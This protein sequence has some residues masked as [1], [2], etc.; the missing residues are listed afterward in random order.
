MDEENEYE[1]GFRKPPEQ[2][3][4]KP[5]RSGNPNG[6]PKKTKDM[7]KLL[8]AELNKTLKMTENGQIK[9]VTVRE[10]FVKSVINAG[11]RGDRDARRMV[12]AHIAKQPDMDGLEIDAA[13]KAMLQDFLKQQ[14]QAERETDGSKN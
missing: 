11:L 8:E 5:G 3:Q 6:R 2:Y 4:F 9:T 14:T 12:F 7:E 1:V 13:A 10:A